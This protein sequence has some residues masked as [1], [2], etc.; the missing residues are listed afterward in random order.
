MAGRFVR[1]LEGDDGVGAGRDRRA[2][3][4]ADGRAGL[5]LALVD[6]TRGHLTGD[7]QRLWAGLA[8]A[9]CV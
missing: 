9:R 4:D 5:D 8:G 7:A 1:L 6:I 3:H 2:G